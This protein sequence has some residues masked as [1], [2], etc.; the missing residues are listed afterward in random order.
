LLVDRP[1][2]A[3]LAIADLSRWKDWTLQDRLMEIYKTGDPN[4]PLGEI[5]VRQAV[6]R[7]MI[8]STLDKPETG[9]PP[10]HVIQGRKHLETL[11]E[12]DPK[13]VGRSERLMLPR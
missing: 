3:D 2:V 4:N 7:Y 6:I 9:D 10:P 11:R 1:E 12:L 8:A 13:T 5:S